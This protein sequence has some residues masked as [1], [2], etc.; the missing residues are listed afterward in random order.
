[1]KQP[2]TWRGMYNYFK[3]AIRTLSYFKKKRRES[4]GRG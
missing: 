1:M 2:E 4:H 3:R